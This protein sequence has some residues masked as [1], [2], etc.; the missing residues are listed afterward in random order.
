M[1]EIA[2]T[3][4]FVA[5]SATGR[6]MALAF[7]R[8][9]FTMR[10]QLAFFAG[11]FLLDVLLWMLLFDDSAGIGSQLFWAALFAAGT[12]AAL[13]TLTSVIAYVRVVRGARVRLFPGALLESGFGT[14]HM[15]LRNPLAESRVSYRSV[16]SLVARGDYVFLRHR[17]TPL[18]AVYP[19]ELFPGEARARIRAAGAQAGLT[20]R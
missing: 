18:V 1:E 8:H 7:V 15:V 10:S 2:Y 11:F 5:D 19:R 14:E 17:G 9:S 16:R 6:K 3:H 13:A 12:T 20:T 4:R